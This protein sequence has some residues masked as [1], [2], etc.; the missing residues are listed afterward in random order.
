MS[1]VPEV[2]VAHH[3]G[4]KCFGIS[5]VANVGLDANINEVSHDEVQENTKK[6]QANLSVLIKD[7]IK[8]C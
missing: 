5:I 3:A 7:L 6:A 8:F 1:T 2:I 4:I